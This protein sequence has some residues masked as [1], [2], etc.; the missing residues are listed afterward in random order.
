ML[1]FNQQLNIR[2]LDSMYYIYPDVPASQN[3]W[4]GLPQIKHHGQ[5]EWILQHIAMVQ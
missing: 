3:P 1:N 5:L 4:Y 2:L